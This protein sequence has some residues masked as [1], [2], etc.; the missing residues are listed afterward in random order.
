MLYADLGLKGFLRR[1]KTSVLLALFIFVIL[2]GLIFCS[3]IIGVC[4]IYRSGTE[5]PYSDYHRVVL[6]GEGDS[7]YNSSD[8]MYFGANKELELFI[9]YFENVTDY[10]Y[11]RTNVITV[12]NAH[13]LLYNMQ[14]AAGKNDNALALFGV[15]S[16]MDYYRF[17]GGEYVLKEGRLLTESDNNSKRK[18]CMISD[19]LALLNNFSVGDKLIVTVYEKNDEGVSEERSEELVIV[20]I[21]SD[22][23]WRDRT[24]SVTYDKREDTNTVFIPLNTMESIVYTDGSSIFNFNVLLD[25][26]S[27]TDE[28]EALATKYK[29]GINTIDICDVN[30]VKVSDFY[31]AENKGVHSLSAVF[32]FSQYAFILIAFVLTVVFIYTVIN[33]RRKEM[34]IYLALGS[35]KYS[36]ILSVAVEILLSVLIGIFAAVLT[37]AVFLDDAALNILKN[38]VE[39]ISSEA[40]R[41]T[42][43]ADMTG[44]V[45]DLTAVTSMMTGDF[46]LSKISASVFSLLFVFL[47][48]M[49]IAV[50][51]IFSERTIKLLSVK[52]E[53]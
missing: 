34:G 27:L 2:S 7:I 42:T 39:N 51:K 43:L 50:L 5:A 3:L 11:I 48:G 24:V 53:V 1:R 40:I 49:A 28:I 19:E 33:G 26:E 45:R 35:D 8:F 32:V 29:L 14:L 12:K 37:G 17:P 47:S 52:R 13:A 4:D 6:S 16:C 20:G 18:V 22:L 31:A 30:L 25:D 38:A 36:V 15:S 9:D 41:N 23:L 21:Y 46:I 44:K 10:N